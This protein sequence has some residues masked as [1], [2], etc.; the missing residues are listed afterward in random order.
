MEVRTILSWLSG[1]TAPG[2]LAEGGGGGA[3]N[4]AE[5]L[6]K[7]VIIADAHRLGHGGD[8]QIALHQHPFGGVDP[9]L[10]D[11][12]GQGLSSGQLLCQSTQLGPANVHLP[13]MEAR[14]SFSI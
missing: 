3:R 14:D 4:R 12:I 6:G 5:Y 7:I 2:I 9:P 11:E 13:E 1:R 8:G 10:G